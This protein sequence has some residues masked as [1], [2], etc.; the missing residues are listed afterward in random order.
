MY[1]VGRKEL[2]AAQTRV[3]VI[4]V[5]FAAGLQRTVVL[6]W[7]FFA[8]GIT[9]IFVITKIKPNVG[10]PVHAVWPMYNVGGLRIVYLVPAGFEQL[11]KRCTNGSVR[12]IYK[13]VHCQYA[14]YNVGAR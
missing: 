11:G 12:A 2:G 3:G 13:A 10:V 4:G 6:H 7:V 14:R 5:G 9:N 8:G 1:G